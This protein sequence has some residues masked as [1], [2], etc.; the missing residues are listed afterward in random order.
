MS[1]LQS[2]D[3]IQDLQHLTKYVHVLSPENARFVEFYF[4]IGDPAL[5]VELIM[6]PSAFA[7]FC[8]HNQ[9]VPMSPEQVANLDADTE[10]WRYGENTLMARNTERT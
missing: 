2:Q 8:A 9:V 1:A 5:M 7:A 4:A 10:K 6:P 3:S